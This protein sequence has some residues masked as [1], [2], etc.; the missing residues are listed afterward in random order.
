M[1]RNT[2]TQV[3]LFKV[4]ILVFFPRKVSFVPLSCW[5]RI[6]KGLQTY[7][8]SL[9]PSHWDVYGSC[10]FSISCYIFIP[11]PASR[12]PLENGWGGLLNLLWL[13]FHKMRRKGRNELLAPSCLCL[14]GLV[15]VEQDRSQS[16]CLHDK[17]SW[18]NWPDVLQPSK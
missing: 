11:I 1:C 7:R 16:C 4:E 5:K 12:D 2:R 8:N 18:Q 9:F 6:L 3:V 17:E 14:L 13:N 15:S 10:Q